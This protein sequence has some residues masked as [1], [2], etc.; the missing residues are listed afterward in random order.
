MATMWLP[1]ATWSLSLII[2]N[3]YQSVYAIVIGSGGM[4]S[5]CT[6]GVARK[7]AGAAV[8]ARRTLHTTQYG[9][10]RKPSGRTAGAS[11]YLHTHMQDDTLARSLSTFYTH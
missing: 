9:Q 4:G 1:L 8:A 2:S 5:R 7:L 3:T 6:E 10:S 11:M